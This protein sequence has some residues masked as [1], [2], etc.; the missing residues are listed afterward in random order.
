ML[1]VIGVDGCKDGWV[2]VRLENGKFVDATVFGQFADGVAESRDAAVIGVDIP[3]GFPRPPAQRRAADDEARAMVAPLWSTVF[4]APH[5]CVYGA[6]NH[7]A[8]NAISKNRLGHGIT[9]QSF[10]L[11]P[12][13]LEVQEVAVRNPPIR[14]YEVHPEVSFRAL[15]DRPLTSKKR[16]NGHTDRRA[17]LMKAGIEIPDHLETAKTATTDD[18]L[19][20]AAA[21][22]SANRIA[23]GEA[24][25]LPCP[26]EL[27]KNGRKVA[28]W[29]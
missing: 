28:I 9:A 1:V 23:A 15:A 29:Y 26:P 10:G 16:W 22:W 2:F 7:A 17:L 13:I 11:V 18:V 6:Q 20:A 19:D 21:A 14:I 4:P 24:I 27:D 8:A 5:P 12:K 3:I 25:P